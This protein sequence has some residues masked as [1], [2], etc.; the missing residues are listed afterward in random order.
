MIYDI[1]DFNLDKQPKELRDDKVEP[2]EIL[3]A[4]KML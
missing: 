3:L 4:I 2:H 1:S